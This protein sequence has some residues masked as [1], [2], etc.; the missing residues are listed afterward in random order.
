MRKTR[1]TCAAIMRCRSWMSSHLAQRQ[2]RYEQTFLCPRNPDMTPWFLHRAHF[3]M[4]PC[5]ELEFLSIGNAF[6]RLV[7]RECLTLLFETLADAGN[8]SL[9]LV[10]KPLADEIS[11]L[12]SIED[13][14]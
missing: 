6:P 4:R 2:F 12:V 3:G 13:G 7:G 5:T 11:K 9:A 14:Y 8:I 1:L 10:T